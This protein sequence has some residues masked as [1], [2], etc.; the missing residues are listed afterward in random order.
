MQCVY[1]T[2]VLKPWDPRCNLPQFSAARRKEVDVLESKE[3]LEV[4]LREDVP[5]NANVLGGR[6]V[7]AV[8]NAGTDEEIY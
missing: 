8:K 1:L 4:V 5:K 2:K 7:L 3:T 6:F